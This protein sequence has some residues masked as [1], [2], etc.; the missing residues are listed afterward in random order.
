M[1]RGDKPH[2]LI[3][4]QYI[5]KVYCFQLANCD[6]LF[7]YLLFFLETLPKTDVSIFLFQ[8]CNPGIQIHCYLWLINQ[9]YP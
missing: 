3:G 1:N 6:V 9:H 7:S 4:S 5:Y 8:T 2:L